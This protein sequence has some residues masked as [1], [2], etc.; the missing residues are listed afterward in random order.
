VWGH[1]TASFSANL[2]GEDV[3][4][5]F[6]DLARAAL[7]LYANPAPPPWLAS[8][9]LVIEVQSDDDGWR[10]GLDEPSAA[11]VIAAGGQPAR[12]RIR[13]EVADDFRKLYGHLYP[14]AAQWVT[15][16]SGE[17]LLELG[18]AK[19][20]HGGQKVAEWPARP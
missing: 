2:G 18:G 14:H 7:E 5:A 9:A 16:L 1:A 4:D 6:D 19:F 12:V 3:G 20:V 15:N 13:H 8:P 10:F 11:R 17:A